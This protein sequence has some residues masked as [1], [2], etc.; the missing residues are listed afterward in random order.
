[1]HRLCA[2]GKAAPSTIA[3]QVKVIHR[4]IKSANVLLDRGLVARIGDFGIAHDKNNV[5]GMTATHIQ[6]DHVLGTLVYMPPE[7]HRGE[8]STK[9]DAYA[10]GLVL[11]EALT[12][13]PIA[14][15]T[16][17]FR[18]LYALYERRTRLG[19]RALSTPRPES[20]LVGGASAR[21][22]RDVPQH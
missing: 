13:L 6:I 16:D 9:I 4:D 22:H 19:L 14:A 2:D 17:S 15:P 20:R 10:F 11:L 18:D 1:M 5:S 21:P 3:S 12:G 7:Y 8:L